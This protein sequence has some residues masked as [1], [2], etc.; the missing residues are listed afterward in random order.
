VIFREVVRGVIG[1]A[2]VRTDSD[3]TPMA[4]LEWASPGQATYAVT[5]EFVPAA[6]ARSGSPVF[7]SSTS[8]LAY[9]TTGLDPK[10]VELLMPQTIRVGD[11]AYVIVHVDDDRQGRVS[12]KVDGRRMSL[13]KPVER[14]LVKFP[15]VPAN[16]GV[17]D[18][19]VVFHEVGVE[20]YSSQTDQNGIREYIERRTPSNVVEQT[21]DVL[22]RLPANPISVSPVVK[23]VAGTPWQD[24]SVV[25]YA[26]GTRVRLVSSTGNGAPVAFATTGSCAIGGN[27]LYLPPSMTSVLFPAMTVRVAA[28]KTTDRHWAGESGTRG[29]RATVHGEM[30]WNN[31]VRTYSDLVRGHHPELM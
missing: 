2:E 3:D 7:A 27:T 23:G 10:R 25:D 1:E 12:L 22:D 18:V 9:F 19:Q 5:G 6:D 24:D 21:V 20:A 31:Y 28:S 15:W 11:S 13:D 8:D 4:R 17:A 30:L 26:A 16:P 29:S 14:D